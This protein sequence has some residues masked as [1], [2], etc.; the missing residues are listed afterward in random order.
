MYVTVPDGEDTR[1][2]LLDDDARHIHGVPHTTAMFRRDVYEAAGG[3]RA[4][5][6]AAQDLDLWIRMARHG[7]IGIAPEVLS[8]V[9]VDPRGV[10]GVGRTAQ[11]RLT[12]IAVALRDGGNERALLD[13]AARI[14]PKRP[15]RR[16]QAAAFYFIGKCL[17]SQGNPRWRAYLRRALAHD[18]LHLRSWVSLLLGR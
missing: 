13:A 5:F 18:P 10:S 1:R 7:T 9:T 8:V 6:R 16:A 2:S 4:E 17:L 3:Y 15:T 11:V 14:R 12:E